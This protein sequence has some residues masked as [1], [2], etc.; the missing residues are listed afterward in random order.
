MKE[1]GVDSLHTQAKADDGGRLSP[2]SGD[3]VHCPVVA[4]QDNRS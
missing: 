3:V 4:V 1:K 2:F